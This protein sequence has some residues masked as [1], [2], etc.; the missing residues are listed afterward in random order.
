MKLL[1]LGAADWSIMPTVFAAMLSAGFGVKAAYLV[2]GAVML[3]VL[4]A[5]AWAWGQRLPWLPGGDTGLGVPVIYS[6][7]LC[8]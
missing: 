1:E 5:V 4:A 2:Q 3:A 7:R 6:L 8:L